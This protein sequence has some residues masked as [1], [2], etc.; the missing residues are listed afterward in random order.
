VGAD[1]LPGDDALP[2]EVWYIVS[3]TGT[4]AWYLV[5]LLQLAS[6]FRYV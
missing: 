3:D 5:K 6:H 4:I 2:G 1:A